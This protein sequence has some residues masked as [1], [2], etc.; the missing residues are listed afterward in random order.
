MPA[1][2][3]LS[4]WAKRML[5]ARREPTAV[6]IHALA[7]FCALQYSN[8]DALQVLTGLEAHGVD[9]HDRGRESRSAASASGT[10]FGPR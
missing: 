8:S 6:R 4:W 10:R 5:A 1:P 3:N 9:A 7:R 2:R